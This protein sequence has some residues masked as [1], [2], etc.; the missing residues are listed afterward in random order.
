M[1]DELIKSLNTLHINNDSVKVCKEFDTSTN[2]IECEK[3]K[4][5]R[6]LKIILNECFDSN[7]IDNTNITTGIKN[8]DQ[9]FE[10]SINKILTK[11]CTKINKTDMSNYNFIKDI[12]YYV[13]QPYGSQKPPDFILLFKDY[14]PLKIECKSSTNSL[15]ATWNCSLPEKDIIYLFYSKKI[16]KTLIFNGGEIIKEDLKNKFEELHKKISILTKEFNKS[17]SDKDC[18][19]EYYPRKMFNQI[20]NFNI[21]NRD[22][23]NNNVMKSIDELYKLV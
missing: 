22:L 16:N 4:I 20:L 9:K 17:I 11:Y 10:S 19:F 14:K 18:Y 12:I 6:V 3:N 21:K 2:I 23:Y 13:S 15:K 5:L 7:N 1:E 8:A